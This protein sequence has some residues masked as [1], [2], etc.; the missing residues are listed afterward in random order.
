MFQL[1]CHASLFYFKDQSGRQRQSGVCTET[2]PACFP[3]GTY[4][5]RF[6]FRFVWI[7][8][9]LLFSSFHA[10][11][12]ANLRYMCTTGG[13]AICTGGDTC[14]V[15]KTHID[16]H[17]H[18][19]SFWVGRSLGYWHFFLFLVVERERRSRKNH[20]LFFS[21]FYFNWGFFD[22]M[23]KLQPLG[24]KKDYMPSSV[25]TILFWVLIYFLIKEKQKM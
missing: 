5:T 3:H 24:Y 14:A 1:V 7:F 22:T 12:P 4:D 18:A 15:C 25:Q 10:H 11:N 17:G 20:F 9:S 6:W 13:V 21:F 8:T 2:R 23:W 19:N 16:T